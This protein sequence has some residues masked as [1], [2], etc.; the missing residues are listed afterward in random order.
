VLEKGNARRRLVSPTGEL[1]TQS[2]RDTLSDLKIQSRIDC[3]FGTNQSRTAILGGSSFSEGRSRQL[4]KLSPCHS[5]GKIAT[6]QE[7]S[8]TPRLNVMPLTG[9]DQESRRGAPSSCPDSTLRHSH[10]S[11]TKS[12]SRTIRWVHVTKLEWNGR[13]C[14]WTSKSS[15]TGAITSVIH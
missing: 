9:H 6:V 7:K 2:R 5:P 4:G 8:S 11:R 10:P 12:T 14:T 15:K 13:N 1:K 3:L